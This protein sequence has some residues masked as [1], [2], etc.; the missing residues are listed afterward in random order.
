MATEKPR[1]T[2]ECASGLG[3]TYGTVF[4]QWAKIK[5]RLGHDP[6]ERYKELGM[7]EGVKAGEV[8]ALRNISPDV[9][10]KL[11]EMNQERLLRRL[12]Q[13]INDVPPEKIPAMIRDLTN[14]RA[15][16]KGEPTQILRV[17]QR[18]NLRKIL[19]AMLAEA[20]RRGVTLE[21]GD[22]QARVIKTI[23]PVEAE[24]AVDDT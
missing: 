21:L 3:I 8:L 15:L 22:G 16:I 12:H 14:A 17:D 1:T 6:L 10:V 5:A 18:E 11:T 20:S 7:I 4:S 13:N 2:A 9:I 24:L 23:K 19:P